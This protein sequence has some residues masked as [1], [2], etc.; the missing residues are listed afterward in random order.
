M[1]HGVKSEK[2]IAATR[3]STDYR[4]NTNHRHFE[5]GLSMSGPWTNYDLR[6]A[7]IVVALGQVEPSNIPKQ[8]NGVSSIG[9][10][11]FRL[12]EPIR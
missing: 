6:D 4:Q 2:E 7:I 5:P 3:V 1:L 9:G 8:F 12:L 10:T 11:F